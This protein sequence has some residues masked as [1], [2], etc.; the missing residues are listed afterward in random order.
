MK[1]PYASR[2]ASRDV[3][4][5]GATERFFVFAD[6]LKGECAWWVKDAEMCAVTATGTRLW[7]NICAEVKITSSEGY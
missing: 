5:S 4:P 2:V 1:C 3:Y 6:C 7:N